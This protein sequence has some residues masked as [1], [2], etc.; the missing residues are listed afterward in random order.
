MEEFKKGCG[1]PAITV[2]KVS[3]FLYISSAVSNDWDM[4]YEGIFGK[5][6]HPLPSEAISEY[7]KGGMEILDWESISK[8]IDET[9]F[10][11]LTITAL[12]DSS[13]DMNN[14]IELIGPAFPSGQY[15]IPRVIKAYMVVHQNRALVLLAKVLEKRLDYQ[16]KGKLKEYQGLGSRKPDCDTLKLILSFMK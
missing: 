9:D 11:K 15:D 10:S 5:T 4:L 12:R 7:W 13:D 6:K 3:K 2:D 14:F 8:L 1:L 16:T